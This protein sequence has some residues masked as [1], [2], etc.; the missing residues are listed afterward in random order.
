MAGRAHI[1]LLGGFVVAVDGTPVPDASW[2]LRKSRSVLK[3]LALAPQRSLNPERLQALLWPDR[4]PG[5][6]S[7]NLR[8]AV[9][10]ARRALTGAGA[11]GAAVL[12]LHGDLLTLA[13]AVEVDVDVFERAAARAEST[14]TAADIEAALAAYGGEL[15]PEDVYE[16]WAAEPRRV[17][18]DRH[19]R[20]LLALAATR[21]AASATEPLH[22]AIAADP[23]N[24]EA[25]RALMRSYAS[26]G[27]RAQALAQ[28]EILRATLERELAAD[29][30]PD[31]RALYRQL[32]AEGAPVASVG[33]APPEGGAPVAELPARPPAARHNLPWQPTS[34]VGRRRELE[35]IDRT[36]DSRR[37]VTLTGPGGCGKT[38][39]ALEIAERR[40]ERHPDGAWVIEFAGVADSS[41]VGQATAVALGL[42]LSPDEPPEVSLAR[43]LAGRELLLLL[44]NCE[45]LLEACARL[46]QTVLAQ[47]PGVTILA[48]SRE[49]LHLPGEVDWRVPSMAMVD[50]AALSDVGE[51]A[52]VDAVELFC[53]RARSANPRFELSVANAQAVAEI[54]LR[55]DGLPLAIELA[56][57]RTTALSP[58]EIASR[59]EHGLAVLRAKRA[60]GLTRQQTLEAT[61]DW[62]HDMLGEN[63]R[64]LFRRLSVFAGGCELEAVERVTSDESMP[65]DDV[66]ETLAS[67]VDKSLVGVDDAE[68]SYR[69]RLLEPVRQYAAARLAEAGET[70]ALVS[71]HA[72][73]F[74]AVTDKPGGRVTDVDARWVARLERD[75]D[76][77]RA[78]MSWLLGHRPGRALEMASGMTGLWLLRA[79]LREGCRWLDR[80]LAAQPEASPAR[81]DAMH[82]RQA[83]ERRRPSNYDVADRLAQG[84]IAIYRESKDRRN[85]CLAVLDLADGALLRGRLVG[86][87][88]LA[89]Q[90]Q[91]LA[92]ALGDDGLRAATIERAG[93]AAAWRQDFDEAR[94][95]FDEAL[96]LCEAAPG[97]AAPSSAVISLSGFIADD[98]PP[99]AYPVLRPE[100]TSLHFRRLSPRGARASLLSHRAYLLRCS[101]RYDDSRAELDAAL[102]IVRESGSALDDARLVAQRGALE[103][104][105]GDLEAAADW[106][107]RSLT[108]RRQLREHRGIL[109]TLSALALVASLAGDAGRSADLLAR[110]ARMGEEAVDGPGM[111]AVLLT[112]AEI[113]RTQGDLE[114]ARL[115]LDGALT[116]FYEVTGLIHYA[117][118]VHLQHAYLS[119]EAGDNGEAARRLDFAWNGFTES[120]TQLGLD[121]CVALGARLRGANSTLTGAGWTPPSTAITE[122]GT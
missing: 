78:A 51:L 121:H 47:C 31:T 39:L 77:L 116:V 9:Y 100:E 22:R 89:G 106:L 33:T 110:A 112:K 76:N 17:L 42:D 26:S 122:E 93:V 23:L 21:D 36:V 14:G 88:A 50:T 32:L 46:A 74:A 43:H 87:V 18:A 82:A 66:L 48:T 65:E 10:H 61:L 80:A 105:A 49:P 15:L 97:D 98:K 8:Q 120:R 81:A 59:L 63:E 104:R 19:V 2:R 92:D 75:H 91:V 64:V 11:N 27:R 71:R 69:Y 119:A 3:V 38:R 95:A 7:N 41:L 57:A 35:E 108:L 13:G 6:A 99:T 86:A 107:G 84:R 5:A 37:L 54:C 56:A 67:L 29:P 28:Y 53:D 24:E 34:F 60:T 85:E 1:S 96:A 12:D 117:S 102:A 114:Q 73:W 55:V 72:E 4:E 40:L 113:C 83:L 70:A 68:G 94:R 62:S 103:T 109:L 111:G 101:G 52:T 16:D 79:H 45:H 58:A 25:H 44:D 30:E 90:A 20:L 115:A 118:W